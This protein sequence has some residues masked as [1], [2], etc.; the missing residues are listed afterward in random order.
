[1][2][3]VLITFAGLPGSGK[4]TIARHLAPRLPA[5]WLRIDVIEQCLREA[6]P[7]RHDLGADGY[8]IA[9]AVAEG[10]L[11]TGHHVIA[12]SVNPI[13]LTR[14]IWT[15][16]ADAAEARQLRVEVIC[17]DHDKHRH[18]VENRRPDI[19]GLNLPDWQGVL[20]R[21]YQP[22]AEADLQIDTAKQSPEQAVDAILAA[23]N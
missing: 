3:A 9:A 7:E 13:A 12:D 14:D 18:R 2:T 19:I 4:S 17:S 5:M 11:A 1:M 23:L 16:I 6:Q 15:A 10:N 20:N 21:E 22:W 8:K